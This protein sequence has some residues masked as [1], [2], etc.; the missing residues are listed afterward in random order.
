MVIYLAGPMT[1]IKDWN[2]PEFDRVEQLL[3]A[4]GH[5]VLN[6]ASH[7]PKCRPEAIS[8]AEYMKISFAM[9]DA[10][11]ALVLLPGWENSKGAN[12]ER[13]HADRNGLYCV[14]WASYGAE[15]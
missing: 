13:D 11:E 12:L 4:A 1:G 2:K 14:T 6:P 8:H 15:L 3:S 10:A 7:I 5:T 9:I